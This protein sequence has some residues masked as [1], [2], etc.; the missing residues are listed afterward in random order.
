MIAFFDLDRTLL[1]CNSA[2]LW[3]RH[4][5]R[6]GTIN[7]KTALW[8]SYWLLRYSLGSGNIEHAIKA[9]VA[10]LEGQDEDVF[11]A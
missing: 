1:D 11:A 10:H 4:E 3:L 2:R 9:A 6:E 7:V 8:A 5:W